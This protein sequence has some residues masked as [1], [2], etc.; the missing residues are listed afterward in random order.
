MGEQKPR[1]DSRV[2]VKEESR[3]R[4][5]QFGALGKDPGRQRLAQLGVLPSGAGPKAQMS[6]ERAISAAEVTQPEFTG[7]SFHTS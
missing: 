7:L 2:R 4:Y 6:R 3:E 1:T 5:H